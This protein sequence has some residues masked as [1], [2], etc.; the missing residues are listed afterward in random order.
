M[1]VEIE[2]GGVL[3]ATRDHRLEAC[4]EGYEF[5]EV[6]MRE[7]CAGMWLRTSS[8]HGRAR[9]AAVR[10]GNN[11][12][13]SVVEFS[14]KVANATAMLVAGTEAVSIF[15]APHARVAYQVNLLKGAYDCLDVSSHTTKRAKTEPCESSTAMVCPVLV[16]STAFPA[17]RG[18][19]GHPVCAGACAHFIR[20]SCK[21]GILCNDC[22]VEG[23]MK[24]RTRMNKRGIQRRLRNK[25]SSARDNTNFT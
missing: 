12:V 25:S 10:H 16:S 21:F 1:E 22:H 11:E 17:S 6:C 14:L 24:G 3:K 8:G 13:G 23:C 19:V 18:S 7:L 15:G 20:G 5:Q 2:S 9:I 4:I